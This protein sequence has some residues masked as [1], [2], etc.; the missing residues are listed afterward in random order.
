[1][2]HKMK[3]DNEPFTLIQSGKKTIELRLY[4]EKRRR[5][6]AGDTIIFT[7]NSTGGVVETV[8]TAIHVF[9]SFAEL[10][11]ALPLNKCGYINEKDADPADMEKYYSKQRQ[12]ECGVV[13]I[14]LCTADKMALLFGMD[15]KDYD[16]EWSVFRRDS[17]RAIMIK[18][19]RLALVH[20]RKYG[21]YK[22][23]G[24]GIEKG[25]TKVAALIRETKEETGL[26]VKEDSVRVYGRIPRVQKDTFYENMIFVQ[27]NYY[28]FCE[29]SD[30][31][32]IQTL[33]GYEAEEGFTSELVEPTEAIRQNKT[34]FYTDPE[35]ID[36][37]TMM[38]ELLI[39][40]GY[41]DK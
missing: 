4:D 40:E 37:D 7:N 22:F 26:S 30:T 2:I 10:Y 9:P 34:V 35:L 16:P 3:L 41:F 18:D 28:Y 24:G 25:E 31:A 23:P 21:Y 6:T 14:E 19:G 17:A 27:E 13:G 12:Q 15:K 39:D 36:R 11:K 8:V 1:M 20:S 5:V 33:D 29:A 32:A 38:M